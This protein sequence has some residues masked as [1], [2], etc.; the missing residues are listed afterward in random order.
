MIELFSRTENGMT[1]KIEFDVVK[2]KDGTYVDFVR[3]EYS[4][5]NKWKNPKCLTDKILQRC[6]LHDAYGMYDESCE[7]TKN[8]IIKHFQKDAK[9]VKEIELMSKHID[10]AEI[11]L[12]TSL[13]SSFDSKGIKNTFLPLI[14]KINGVDV[15]IQFM[16]FDIFTHRAV[17]FAYDALIN[18]NIPIPDRELVD[19]DGVRDLHES[20]AK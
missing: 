17:E 6:Y 4:N 18:G 15:S 20:F 14:V 1:T 10:V 13:R 5:N 16:D 3:S 8:F 7:I 12:P 2:S 9:V 19:F 11:S